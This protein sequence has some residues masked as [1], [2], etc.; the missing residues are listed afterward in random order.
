MVGR[1]GCSNTSEVH[2]LRKKRWEG[3]WGDW[4]PVRTATLRGRHEGTT[5]RHTHTHAR[6]PTAPPLPPPS[7]LPPPFCPSIT[8]TPSLAEKHAEERRNTKSEDQTAG[9]WRS[10][11]S[12][13][14]DGRGEAGRPPRTRLAASSRAPPQESGGTHTHTQRKAGRQQ[15]KPPNTR[16]SEKLLS[17]LGGGTVAAG[18]GHRA[19]TRRVHPHTRTRTRTRTHSPSHPIHAEAVPVEVSVS[20]QR[21]LLSSVHRRTLPR[22]RRLRADGGGLRIRRVCMQVCRGGGGGSVNVSRMR[23]R[24]EKG[25]EKRRCGAWA[26]IGLVRIRRRGRQRSYRVQ[27]CGLPMAGGWEGGHFG[28][29]REQHRNEGS[30]RH[31][32]LAIQGETRTGWAAALG[33]GCMYSVLYKREAK[34]KSVTRTHTRTNA[35]RRGERRT[36]SERRGHRLYMKPTQPGS[37]HEQQTHTGAR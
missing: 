7:A 9:E 34:R 4:G 2:A 13:I 6:T 17:P 27:R 30:V 1:R 3:R 33:Q 24:T 18:S 16:K 37:P 21:A 14:G 31:G 19:S 12:L 8:R 25:G 20:A 32:R 28:R 23:V 10:P 15:G 22:G 5:L 26:H 11:P 36:N 29:T 35:P